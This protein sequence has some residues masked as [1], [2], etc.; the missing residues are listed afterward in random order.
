V[1][2]PPSRSS[3]F[4][5]PEPIPLPGHGPSRSN[6][7]IPPASPFDQIAAAAFAPPAAPP[8]P[9]SQVPRLGPKEDDLLM[10]KGVDLDS[11]AREAA[12]QGPPKYEP[13]DLPGLRS[14][15]SSSPGLSQP[16]P[17]VSSGGFMSQPAGRPGQR[18]EDLPGLR[19]NDPAARAFDRPSSNPASQKR[20][21]DPWSNPSLGV[22]STTPPV[23]ER[24]SVPDR[25]PSNPPAKQNTIPPA[26]SGP[27]AYDEEHYR[28]VYNDF[29]S[30]KARL[31]EAVDNITYEGFRSKLR[32]SEEALINLHGFDAVCFHVV[33]QNNTVTLRS[34]LVR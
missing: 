10:P 4:G 34:Q 22:Y 13:T 9:P 12:K 17:S 5:A 27:V 14:P 20:A 8:Q 19:A 33:V 3:P 6:A 26:A 32:S 24:L 31:G 23:Q 29:V 11:I 16:P 7:T 21:S 30:S 15:F 1:P 25:V 28:V 2:P 18:S